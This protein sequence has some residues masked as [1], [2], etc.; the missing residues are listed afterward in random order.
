M[1][2]QSRQKPKSASGRE[3]GARSDFPVS[4][5]ALQMAGI[6][7][8]CS[9]SRGNL[10]LGQLGSSSLLSWALCVTLSIG[11]VPSLHWCPPANSLYLHKAKCIQ[12]RRVLGDLRS[13]LISG[14]TSSLLRATAGDWGT[15][16]TSAAASLC[17]LERTSLGPCF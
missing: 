13:P 10:A 11:L 2:T 5:K 3:R 17:D 16:T 1:R 4:G 7:Q 9:G 15:V 8:P 12:D 6:F 14:G